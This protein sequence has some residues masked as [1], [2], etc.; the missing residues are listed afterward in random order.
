MRNSDNEVIAQTLVG[1]GI[2]VPVGAI[3]FTTATLDGEP[4][5]VFHVN[6]WPDDQPCFQGE[7]TTVSRFLTG[8]QS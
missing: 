2:D 3:S 1:A 4:V 7:W 5:M 8:A 6:I